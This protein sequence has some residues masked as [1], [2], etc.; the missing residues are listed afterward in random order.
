MKTPLSVIVVRQGPLADS[1]P[2][3]SALNRGFLGSES[4]DSY[5]SADYELVN[6]L[7]FRVFST[8][9][10]KIDPTFER[11][12]PNKEKEAIVSESE[13][14]LVLL[15]ITAPNTSE[16]SEIILKWA[17]FTAQHPSTLTLCFSLGSP[18]AMPIPA[19]L[20]DASFRTFGLDHLDERDLRRD[21]LTLH[22]VHGAL[23]LLAD[24]AAPPHSASGRAGTT[25]E[26][27]TLFFSHAKRDG[28]PLA[29]SLVSWIKR[30]KDFEFFYDTINLDLSSDISAQLEKAIGTSV[31]VV[32]RTEVFDQRYWCQ[33]EVFWAEK[34]GVP[35]IAVDARWN[36]KAAPSVVTL[37]S[38]P[39]VRIPDGSLVRILQAAL[40]EALRVALHRA[41]ANLLAT[42]AGI[43]PQSW[44]VLSRH[45]SLVAL[46][47]SA[48]TS[49]A[50]SS[51][52]SDPFVVVYPNPA[53]P[54][55]L[56]DS[57]TFVLDKLVPNSLLLSLDEFRSYLAHR[58]P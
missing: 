58:L 33:E 8:A 41:R 19:G 49:A 53:L 23:R 13:A 21:F 50:A 14:S 28:V 29:T 10:A 15:L 18:N 9:D 22:S 31:L 25:T 32:L 17:E 34:H 6:P 26:Q 11:L 1:E 16:A 48:K 24:C 35:V 56:R 57:A 12:M 27:P 36:V 51:K 46:E 55:G 38:S 20:P 40:E 4:I 47:S 42:A 2:F 3:L 7:D 52:S 44:V 43:A 45:P 5:T 54:D 39:S 37:D 30:L